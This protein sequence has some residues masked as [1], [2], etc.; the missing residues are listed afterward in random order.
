MYA[1]A[2]LFHVDVPLNTVKHQSINESAA[3][4]AFPN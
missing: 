3:S 1:L 4:L 2:V